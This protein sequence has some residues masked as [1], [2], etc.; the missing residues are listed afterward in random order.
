MSRWFHRAPLPAA[1]TLPRGWTVLTASIEYRF[2]RFRAS[3]QK[4]TR[5][6][7]HLWVKFRQNIKELACNLIS[8]HQLR[9]KSCQ[10]TTMS[11]HLSDCQV[12]T[13]CLDD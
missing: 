9:G 5:R 2:A 10:G 1:A 4:F 12:S 6:K 3:T 8:L 7:P 13:Y 11:R